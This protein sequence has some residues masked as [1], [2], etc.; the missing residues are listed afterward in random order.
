MTEFGKIVFD[1]IGIALRVCS[2]L[3]VI[4]QLYV[5]TDVFL[6]RRS[7]GVRLL[8]AGQLL[9]GLGWFFV[10]LDGSFYVEWVETPRAYPFLVNLI[11]GSPWLVVAAVDLILAAVLIYSIFSVLRYRRLHLSRTAVKETLDMLPVGICFARED[12]TVVLN[13]LQMERLS[14]VL[15]GRL[16]SDSP[17][18]WQAVEEKGEA[19]DSARIVPLSDNRAVLFK[20]DSISS[21]GK[22]YTQITACD[23]SELYQIT[24]ELRSKNKKLID[25][26]TRMKA[27]SAMA[28]RLAMS[29]EILKARV[30]VHDEMGHL[31]LSGKYYLD[32]PSASDPEKLMELERYTHHLLMREGEEPD[33]AKRDCIKKAA[34]IARSMGVSV[35]ISGVLPEKPEKNEIRVLLAQAIRECAANTVKHAGGDRLEVILNASGESL[36]ARLKGNGEPPAK[37]ITESGGLLMIRRKTEA[38]GGRMRVSYEP[39]VVVELKVASGEL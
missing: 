11:Y 4:G 6:Q 14:E 20:K 3:I 36:T 10:L 31:L 13:N 25:L 16:L 30:K 38:A 23:V 33:D 35:S 7:L 39:Q 18:F 28:T 37:P 32:D 26:Q 34:A 29:E 22:P 9:L 2:L 12:G 27:F 15:T 21:N 24:A 5:A 8:A 19:Q 17:S 1:F